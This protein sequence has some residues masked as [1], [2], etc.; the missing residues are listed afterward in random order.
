MTTPVLV[1]LTAPSC[2]GKSYLFNYIRDEAGLPCLIS[3]TTRRPRAGE[4]DGVDYHFITEEE[5]IRMELADE[6][7]EL[8]IYRGVRYG[9]TKEEFHSKLSSD[10]KVAF[11]IV[12]P[13]GID[14]Y[15]KPAIDAGAKH[16]KVYIDVDWEIR[17]ERL[18]KR[19]MSDIIAA[20]PK[21]ATVLNDPFSIFRSDIIPA[22]NT[23]S[24]VMPHFDRLVAMTS[25]ENSW[26]DMVDWDLIV[27]GDDGAHANTKK[28]LE[29]VF[30]LA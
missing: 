30:K 25:I 4:V 10:E 8:A 19:L 27:S 23:I 17:L 11:L 13:S 24:A 1:T 2:G 21:D 22:E 9:V 12:E 6:F 28:I 20:V 16:L 29:A 5:S 26:K 15:A 14:H 7:A 18:K 3:T